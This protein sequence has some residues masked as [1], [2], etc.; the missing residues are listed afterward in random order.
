MALMNPIVNGDSRASTRTKMINLIEYG[1]GIG[2][3]AGIEDYGDVRTK[4]NALAT[5]LGS[6]NFVD[7]ALGSVVLD[8]I[9]LLIP[10]LGLDRDLSIDYNALTNKYYDGGAFDPAAKITDTHAQAMLVPNGSGGWISR[11][12]NLLSYG[13]EGLQTVP[14][15][16]NSIRRNDMV[17]AVV[18]T[19]GTLM[20]TWVAPNTTNGLAR[21]IVATGTDSLTGLPYIEIRYSGTTT[22]ASTLNIQFDGVG[23]IA[24]TIG[25][26][27]ANSV[28]L[29][30]VAGSLSGLNSASYRLAQYNGSAAYAGDMPTS[31][32]ILGLTAT[33]TRITQVGALNQATSATLVPYIQFNYPTGLALD[34]T[35]RIVA[36]QLEREMITPPII[37]SG[38]AVTRTGNRQ[39][40]DLTGRLAQGVAGF[41]KADMKGTG[42]NY[43][44]VLRFYD[45]AD[46]SSRADLYYVN[47]FLFWDIAL[48]GVSQGAISIGAFPTGAFKAAFAVGPNYLIARLVGGSTPAADTVVTF[49]T[50]MNR[51]AIGGVGA[52]A[53]EIS[54]MMTQKLDLKFGPVDQSVFDAMYALAVAA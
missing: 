25:Q 14:T 50:S 22:N 4:L 2:Q 30:L 46:P 54:Y 29:S 11:A 31:P 9:N 36:P 35:I 10:L 13:P 43:I 6:A 17:G 15:A 26:M 45:A 27:W 7:R 16:T 20:A 49:P 41:I 48:V 52:S 42:A 34:F 33:L 40:I 19:P 37:T 12:A 32:S 51:M 53:T 38:A 8:R 28:Y 23:N 3:S 24:G 39:V 5:A 18:G 44:K 21:Q 47:G 1:L